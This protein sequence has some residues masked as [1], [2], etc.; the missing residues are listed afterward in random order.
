MLSLDWQ[1]LRTRPIASAKKVEQL[2]K[3]EEAAE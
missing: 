2:P 1:L 3:N